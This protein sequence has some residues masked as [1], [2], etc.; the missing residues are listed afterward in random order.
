MLE[1]SA[2]KLATCTED[3]ISSSHVTSNFHLGKSQSNLAPPFAIPYDSNLQYPLVQISLECPVNGQPCFGW[4]NSL[5][6]F[7][8]WF[9]TGIM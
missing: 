3:S 1:E 8:P 4:L 5:H 6:Q 2:S 9:P 7:N